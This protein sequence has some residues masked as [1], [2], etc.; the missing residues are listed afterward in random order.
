MMVAAVAIFGDVSEASEWRRA[1]P[2]LSGFGFAGGFWYAGDRS[3]LMRHRA[4]AVYSAVT[5]ALL[6]ALSSGATYEP[7]VWH[8]LG[9]ALPLAAIGAWSLEHFLRPH[10]LPDGAIDA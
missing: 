5:G 2:L 3:G 9:L 6:W 8:L 7:V 10:R 1:A 4:I